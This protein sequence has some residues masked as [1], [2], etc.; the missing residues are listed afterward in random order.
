[1]VYRPTL[2][3]IKLQGYDCKTAYTSSGVSEVFPKSFKQF[4]QIL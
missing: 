3:I 4:G 1:M 2:Q